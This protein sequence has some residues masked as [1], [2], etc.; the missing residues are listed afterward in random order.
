M[1][2]TYPE[3]KDALC[4]E[5][6]GAICSCVTA[7]RMDSLME[8]YVMEPQEQYVGQARGVRSSAPSTRYGFR[9]MEKKSPW[10]RE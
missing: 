1:G 7:L 6:S 3:M 8:I 4:P 9:F 5:T 10:V 2:S